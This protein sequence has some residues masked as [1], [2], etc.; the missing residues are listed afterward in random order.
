M[1]RHYT[2][3]AAQGALTGRSRRVVSWERHRVLCC[4]LQLPRWG[5]RWRHL[6]ENQI[7]H[8]DWRPQHWRSARLGRH[9]QYDS[10]ENHLSAISDRKHH[11]YDA[12]K[13]IEKALVAVIRQGK[14]I[15]SSLNWGLNAKKAFYPQFLFE[16]AAVEKWI[17]CGQNGPCFQCKQGLN[18]SK[19]SLHPVESSISWS[20]FAMSPGA[21]RNQGVLICD[22]TGCK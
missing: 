22:V 5:N 11:R 3:D 12:A 18:S 6:S 2:L 10:A 14:V 19:Q 9:L 16:M 21:S 1:R 8:R 13:T 15:S 7:R 4:Q 17:R 20:W